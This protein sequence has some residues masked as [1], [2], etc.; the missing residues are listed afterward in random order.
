MVAFKLLIMLFLFQLGG[1]TTLPEQTHKYESK[2]SIV[3]SLGLNT[4]YITDSFGHNHYALNPAARNPVWS[5]LGDHIAL[6]LNNNTYDLGVLSITNNELQILAQGV[7]RF[8]YPSWSP[9][10]TELAFISEANEDTPETRLYTVEIN[11]GQ[12][13]RLGNETGF[14]G[15]PSWSP[16]GHEIVYHIESNDNVDIY[17]I[18]PNTGLERE[19]VSNAFNPQWSPDGRSIVFSRTSNG[20]IDLFV[21]DSDGEN[22]HRITNNKGNDFSPS[23][24]PSSGWLTYTC[25]Q[26]DNSNICIS[27]INGTNT[28]VLVNH[29]YYDGWPVWSPKGDKIAFV[30]NYHNPVFNDIWLVNSDGT[31]AFSLTHGGRNS[32][33]AWSP[34]CSDTQSE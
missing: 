32:S 26:G 23:W 12:V 29:P 28:R 8:D 19:I 16:N 2:C 7:F 27:N 18:F 20:Q 17:K 31:N 22:E 4:V 13:E 21:S 9:D 25:E 11:G 1:S 30:S 34:E 5:P 6:I 33:P 10:G 3:Y 15:H 24:D 14:Y